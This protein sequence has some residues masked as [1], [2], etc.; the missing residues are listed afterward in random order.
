MST[1]PPPDTPRTNAA[2]RRSRWPGWIWAIP[3]AALLLVGW[4]GF[5]VMTR[6][7]EDITISFDNVHGLKRDNTNIVFRGMNVG[8]VKAVAL[9]KDGK[10]VDVTVHI[11]DDATRFLT[12]GT[13]FWL[14][15]AKPSLSQPSSLAALLSGPTIV[16]APGPGKATKQFVGLERKPVVSGTS[17]PPQIYEVSLSG[18]VGGL[19]PGE[20]VKL[21]GFTVG[22]VKDVGFRYDARS[23]TLATPVTLALYPSLFP[24]E[25]ATGADDASALT[26]AIDRLV[27]EGLRAR[28]ERD[29]PLIGN[30]QVTLD[31]EPDASGAAPQVVDGVPQI[32]A[33]EQGGLNSIISRVNKVPID[34]IAQNLLDTT[35]HVD[36][37]VSSPRLDDAIAQLDAALTQIR[38]TADSAGPK[39]GKLV[40]SLRRTAAR[41]DETARAADKV[42]GGASSQNGTQQTMREITEAARSVRELADYLDRHPEALLEGRSGD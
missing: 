23:G 22:E 11:D 17:V 6:G 12:S 42:L 10:S 26:A 4:W 24:I 9:A 36:A 39:I 3:L 31:M 29:P 14:R 21:R 20:P 33:A 18:S 40:D 1:D 34:Q 37:L 41:L 16:M 8:K 7:G 35:R 15:G 13:Q 5:R 27:R 25:G 2:V 32:P 19:E 38:G 30:P 28:L